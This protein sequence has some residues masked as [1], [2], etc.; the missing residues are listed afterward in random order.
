MHLLQH[1]QRFVLGK[2][3]RHGQRVGQID[4]R[5]RRMK[6]ILF[7]FY[8]VSLFAVAALSQLNQGYYTTNSTDTVDLHVSNLMVAIINARNPQPANVALTNLSLLSD[9]Q[10]WF[11]LSNDLRGGGFLITNGTITLASSNKSAFD[12]TKTNVLYVTN[13]VIYRV[14]VVP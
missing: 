7:T 12:Q 3:G 10:N 5:F 6:K 2:Q 1:G 9:P 13:G 14:T 8:V 4:W 11:A